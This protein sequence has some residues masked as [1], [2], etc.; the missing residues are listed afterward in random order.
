MSYS[1]VFFTAFF[2]L[3]CLVQGKAQELDYRYRDAAL[4]VHQRIDILLSQMTLEEKVGQLRQCNLSS[5]VLEGEFKQGAFNRIFGDRGAG[6]LESPFFH[7]GDIARL[8]NDGAHLWFI[9]V[10]FERVLEN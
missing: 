9:A 5:E 8:Y 2:L 4:P 10:V 7:T 3:I 1:K 6:T